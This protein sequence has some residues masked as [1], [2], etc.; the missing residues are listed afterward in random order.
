MVTMQLPANAIATVGGRI[1]ARRSLP[2][3][4]FTLPDFWTVTII[5]KIG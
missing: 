5:I 1:G 4:T 3:Q 2:G